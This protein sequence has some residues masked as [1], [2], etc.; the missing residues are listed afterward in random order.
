[1]KIQF[2]DLTIKKSNYLLG[3]EKYCDGGN[4]DECLKNVNVIFEYGDNKIIKQ[5]WEEIKN[6]KNSKYQIQINC[7]KTDVLFS[8]SVF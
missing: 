7:K 2:N 6:Q 1:M 3:T 8:N 5:K 4:W